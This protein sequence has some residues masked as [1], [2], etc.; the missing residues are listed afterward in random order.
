MFSAPLGAGNA[1]PSG[2]TGFCT[3]CQGFSI[4]QHCFYFL[5]CTFLF[6][7]LPSCFYSLSFPVF[8]PSHLPS[9]L[10]PFHEMCL[11][12]VPGTVPRNLIDALCHVPHS[13]IWSIGMGFSTE[14][15]ASGTVCEK[16]PTGGIPAPLLTSFIRLGSEYHFLRDN[17]AYLK[18]ILRILT[19][20]CK[21]FWTIKQAEQKLLISIVTLLLLLA[22]FLPTWA[23]M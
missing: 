11:L 13:C 15:H 17:N 9:H 7:S 23:S 16:I 5:P 3:I 14:R 4:D 1:W 18:E 20:I 21:C 22:F 12:I 19:F 10:L 6:S 8:L 2:C